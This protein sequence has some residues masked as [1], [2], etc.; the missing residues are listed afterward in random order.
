MVEPTD[1]VDTLLD[2]T[3][4]ILAYDG[5]RKADVKNLRNWV[6]NTSSLAEDETAYLSHAEDLLTLLSPRDDALARLVP[7][8]EKIMRGLRRVFRK[9]SSLYMPVSGWS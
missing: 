4:R 1:C 7:L 5:P 6:E 3:H 2:R 8:L 9:V